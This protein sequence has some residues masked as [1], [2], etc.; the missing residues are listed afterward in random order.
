MSTNQLGV[1]FEHREPRTLDL[2]H[3]AVSLLEGVVLLA[4]RKRQG[5]D[6]AGT[7]GSGVDELVPE[8]RRSLSAARSIWKPPMRTT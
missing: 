6:L 8:L 4:D 1:P 7:M 2:H 3:H 5:R